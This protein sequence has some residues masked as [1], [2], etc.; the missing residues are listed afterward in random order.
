ML[1]RPST[2]R[3]LAWLYSCSFVCPFGRP[4]PERCPPRFDGEAPR[5]ELRDRVRDSPERARFFCT[6]R[7]AISLALDAD[8]PRLR[9]LLLIF[10]YCRARLVPFLTPRG[11]IRITPCA[12][13]NRLLWASLGAPSDKHPVRAPVAPGASDRGLPSPERGVALLLWAATLGGRSDPVSRL[14]SRTLDRGKLVAGRS[15]R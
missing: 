4:V 5:V 11:G 15:D 9:A 8:A 7:A 3:R 2:L 6:V 14:L 13:T 1:E 12:D 10:S